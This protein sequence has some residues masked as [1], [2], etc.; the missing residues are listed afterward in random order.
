MQTEQHSV[1]TTP[2]TPILRPI[3][4]DED[5]E[6]HGVSLSHGFRA[7]DIDSIEPPMREVLV[8][9]DSAAIGMQQKS[10][11]QKHSKKRK[12]Q[13]DMYSSDV[14][15]IFYLD[16][17]PALSLDDP[18]RIAI[19]RLS[20]HLRGFTE[21]ETELR[22]KQ[23]QV[24][25]DFEDVITRSKT[26]DV[27][28]QE[29]AFLRSDLKL[30]RDHTTVSGVDASVRALWVKICN[31]LIHIRNTEMA[32]YNAVTRCQHAMNARQEAETK[33][34]DLLNDESIVV[35]QGQDFGPIR[36]RVPSDDYVCNGLKGETGYED[37]TSSQFDAVA[38]MLRDIN[39]RVIQMEKIAS[40]LTDPEEK[41]I[42]RRSL[43]TFYYRVN[44]RLG[45]RDAHV[46]FR[47]L[48]RDWR[49]PEPVGSTNLEEEFPL[50][51]RAQGGADDIVR[52][53]KLVDRIQSATKP[54]GLGKSRKPGHTRSLCYS[55]PGKTRAAEPTS[56]FRPAARDKF[57]ASR[58]SKLEQ[59]GDIHAQSGGMFSQFI[60]TLR[61][62]DD[63][64]TKV[65]GILKEMTKLNDDGLTVKVDI[66]SKVQDYFHNLYKGVADS[67]EVKGVILGL[68]ICFAAVRAYQ[69]R[70]KLW[71][72]ITSILVILAGLLDISDE[73]KGYI[74]K[75][76]GFA[77]DPGDVLIEMHDEDVPGADGPIEAQS[78]KETL[79]QC[80]LSYV[81][82]TMFR[83]LKGSRN[84][85]RDFLKG[86]SDM[87]KMGNGLNYTIDFFTN[88]VQ[89]FLDYM[90][91]YLG[92]PQFELVSHPYPEALQFAKD[93]DELSA[94]FAAGLDLN[95]ENGQL[96]YNLIARG[97]NI[98]AK[99]PSTSAEGREARKVI[100][101]SITSIKSIGSRLARANI[102]GNGPRIAPVGILIAGPTAI[103]KTD[104]VQF[105]MNE[106]TASIIPD[107][108]LDA[109][110]RNHNDTTFTRNVENGFWDGY[111]G[112]FNVYTDDLGQTKDV[113]GI[114]ENPYMEHI[115]ML[116]PGNYSLNMAHLEDKGNTNFRS[117]MVYATTNRKL[118]HLNSMEFDE[119]LCRRFNCA[120]I[121]V[122]RLE[123]STFKG[124]ETELWSRRITHFPPER[125]DKSY[126]EFHRY[127]PETGQT[128]NE[129]PI[130]YEQLVDVIVGTYHK[131]NADG[132]LMMGLH[133]SEKERA[134]R[135]R[136]ER[137]G[138]PVC[139]EKVHAQSGESSSGSV[140]HEASD[141][142]RSVPSISE[143]DV[144][145]TRI[146]Q[147]SG[148]TKD[149]V[150]EHVGKFVGDD[151]HMK[152]AK[153]K[154][155]SEE[156]MHS[157]TTSLTDSV[158]NDYIK[159]SFPYIVKAR[160]IAKK[161]KATIL[162]VS[163]GLVAAKYLVQYLT[164]SLEP[165]SIGGMRK[166]SSN[167]HTQPSA[168]VNKGKGTFKVYNLKPRKPGQGHAQL[169][170]VRAE[171]GGDNNAV[172]IMRSVVK[173][174]QYRMCL[175][176]NETP[177][178]TLTFV[179][180]FMAIAPLHFGE[181]LKYGL[182][183][184]DYDEHSNITIWN[185]CAPKYKVRIPVTELEIVASLDGDRH[186]W[187]VIR[188]PEV[189][190]RTPNILKYWNNAPSVLEKDQFTCMLSLVRGDALILYQAKARPRKEPVEYE[191]Y[192]ITNGFQYDIATERGDCGGLLCQ[193][194]SAVQCEKIIGI[195]TA[196][197]GARGYG[198]RILRSEIEHVLEYFDSLDGVILSDEVDELCEDIPDEEQVDGF[199]A[200]CYGRPITQVGA[201]EIRKTPLHNTYTNS[202]MKPAHL[203]PRRV[204]DE[205]IDPMAVARSKY[206]QPVQAM[207]SRMLDLVSNYV[208]A[209]MMRSSIDSPPWGM[210]KV[211]TFREAVEGI[212]GVQFCEGI[213]RNTSAGYPYK[214]DVPSQ[215]RGK[216]HF[217]GSDG[218]YEFTSS[219]CKELE[220]RVHE[221]IADA[222]IGRRRL[223]VYADFLKD[224]RRPIE[225]V[226]AMK[227]RMISSCPLDLLII[228]RMYFL[229][230]VRWLMANRIY[231]GSAV[232]INNYSS[233]WHSLA[234]EFK[235]MM[236]SRSLALIAGDFSGFDSSMTAQIERK[237]LDMINTWYS[238]GNDGVR[239][240]LWE[241]VCASRHIF[242]HVVYQWTGKNPSG[243]FPTT[244]L[245]TIVNMLL[246]VY[247]FVASY[248]E[249]KC[250]SEFDVEFEVTMVDAFKLA[251][252]HLRYI[253]YGDDSLIAISEVVENFFDQDQMSA[254]LHN[255][256]Y[257]YTTESKNETR[258]KPLR[259]LPEVSFL[260][261]GFVPSEITGQYISPLELSVILEMPMWTTKKDTELLDTCINVDTALR[262]LSLHP[263]AVFDVWAPKIISAA[264]RLLDYSPE[265]VDYRTLQ[266]KTL[267]QSAFL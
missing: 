120:Y 206:C 241:D 185:V 82:A 189:I 50:I 178:G 2:D 84:V 149:F 148:L 126:A 113:A 238:D 248:L 27:V 191:Q 247:A 179:L 17:Q 31:R 92:T 20:V 40:E 151:E 173:R 224:E 244:A 156:L 141:T 57:R 223:H 9:H 75:F 94:R 222:K 3:D 186:D 249:F 107:D 15:K 187:C 119:P 142:L 118:F 65:D 255:L 220:K 202:V 170:G 103:G 188:I 108:Q 147:R 193:I 16:D 183:N 190:Q 29:L 74:N 177:M 41:A 11:N 67:V 8:L 32:L 110:E 181:R 37:P 139:L 160:E 162:L 125:V 209:R 229:D 235:S 231:N 261:R 86:A 26:R 256:G 154:C 72:G 104:M 91:E 259:E 166:A 13:K 164:Q 18:V 184:G 258:V 64:S 49:N 245:N 174:C 167:R 171:A 130:S 146:A 14:S 176:N 6:S 252:D 115:Y 221:V 196:G 150:R 77:E 207:S 61:L 43:F 53:A 85:V 62:D 219:H 195:H 95:Y 81:Y 233:E 127:D 180:P 172:D 227:T 70:D 96:Y 211:F 215:H 124:P 267:S 101:L 89:K 246:I 214:L 239:K 200:Q 169:R 257:K 218:P 24:L 217:F 225:K 136:R 33:L 144:E 198:P 133:Q 23:S 90:T 232:G 79:A 51:V 59:N 165:Q 234:L 4:V 158:W 25:N 155:H 199:E 226:D 46:D 68:V 152:A 201:T 28:V 123:Y 265:L 109:F 69:T 60:P 145:M 73:L 83:D 54:K 7:M 121:M 56:S 71:V 21:S 39:M 175:P 266:A 192:T 251:N 132:A 240:L 35:A 230:F 34:N 55:R 99:I 48:Y 260:K 78:G 203:R 97:G 143:E 253:C 111:H 10:E 102:V 262:E 117:K 42:V 157:S 30:M 254:V 45:D 161:Y 93:C 106:V 22:E 264:R 208:L 19:Q 159:K 105:L 135:R 138:F 122:P 205:I 212:P 38:E 228:H 163:S 168:K 52:Y 236:V 98:S 116:G 128:Y 112:Q 237:V 12:T 137:M 263:K 1:C 243:A 204:G 80:V 36:R 88:L 44:V 242:S 153:L 47:S 140:Y 216:S 76:R 194:N 210:P 134:I 5:S 58:D 66:L 182:V 131:M 87:P 63:T 197:H 250:V 100:L 129:P 114:T 213:P